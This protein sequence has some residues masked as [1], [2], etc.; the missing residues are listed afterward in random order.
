ML[1]D[2]EKFQYLYNWLY[3]ITG[4]MVILSAISSEIKKNVWTQTKLSKKLIIFP[5]ICL[6]FLIGFR[7]YNVGTDTGNYYSLLWLSNPESKTNS[8]IMFP[9][10]A[11]YFHS[12]DL[13][14]TV[15]L[16]FIAFLY[17]FNIYR[18]L[19]NYTQIFK[20]NLLMAYFAYMS[21]FFFL[22]MGIN[23]IR[24]GVALSFLLLAYSLIYKQKTIILLNKHIF[25]LVLIITSILFHLTS[26]IAIMIFVFVNILPINNNRFF[27]IIIFLYFFA[28]VLSFFKIGFINIAPSLSELMGEDKRTA[29][30]AGESEE[31]NIGFKPQFVAFNTLFLFISL[32][33]RKNLI[34]SKLLKV[35]T[36]L[37]FYYI[38]ASITL[39][40][41]FQFAYSDR[42]G[43]FSWI[44]IPFLLAPLF[45]SPYMKGHIKIHFVFMLI[46]IYL[47]FKLYAG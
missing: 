31:Y 11:I 2:N 34:D 13:S 6:I 40:F 17:F 26:F 39:F 24:Q 42:W 19:R 45:Y 33:V 10:L 18:A 16:F 1:I 36:R 44:S 32:H 5:V 9:K 38:F 47:G 7:A 21:M 20:S 4:Y 14:Y 30:L 23:V 12:L 28:I 29:Y 25:I 41:A 35:Y 3:F 43:L 37:I 46:L 27:K 8:E 22:S 15:F